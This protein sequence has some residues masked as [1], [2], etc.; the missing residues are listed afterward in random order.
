MNSLYRMPNKN[1]DQL[2]A[3]YAQAQ[4]EL[5]NGHHETIELQNRS[6]KKKKKKRKKNEEAC[7]WRISTRSKIQVGGGLLSI[8]YRCLASDDQYKLPNR[9]SSSSLVPSQPSSFLLILPSTRA[10][11][12][13]FQRAEWWWQRHPS[14]ARD[15]DVAGFC[16]LAQ[17]RTWRVMQ[18][19]I[20]D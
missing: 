7:I 20:A 16:L 6:W 19:R 2:I 4:E 12:G 17:V 1:W 13:F 3:K 10:A 14:S 5:K 18:R 15:H 9:R 8:R 11:Y